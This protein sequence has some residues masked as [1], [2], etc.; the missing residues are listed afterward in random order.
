ML[1]FLNIKYESSKSKNLFTF[2]L[3]IGFTELAKRFPQDFKRLIQSFSEDNK[4]PTKSS[5]QSSNDAIRFPGL[6][7]NVKTLG[8]DSPK[9]IGQLE[10]LRSPALLQ[11]S[12]TS[13]FKSSGICVK[14]DSPPHGKVSM[15]PL[16]WPPLLVTFQNL[17]IRWTFFCRLG[18][19]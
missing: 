18:G 4:L 16:P 15:S 7:N 12:F 10:K 6:S 2:T 14:P 3:C 5:F 13:D 8:S 17:L 9:T 1:L 19:L 11:N